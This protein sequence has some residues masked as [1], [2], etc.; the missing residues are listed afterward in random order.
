VLL[1]LGLCFISAAC[2]NGGVVL[3]S[4][5]AYGSGDDRILRPSLFARLVRVR[6]WVLGTLLNVA[7]WAFQVWA[8]TL[9]SL[10]FVQP[11]LGVGVLFLLAFAWLVFGS[12]PTLR[13]VLSAS[14]L[15][16]GIAL[17]TRAAPP[18]QTGTARARTWVAVAVVL[19]AVALA[20]LAL[21]A[22]KRILGP[23][24]LAASVGFAFALTGLS[25]EVT[26]RGLETHRPAVLA[27]GAAATAVFGAIGFLTETSAL[28][29]A[30]VTAVVP[31]IVVVDTVLP[32][33]LAPFL[34]DERWPRSPAR[35]AALAAGIV[36]SVGGAASL[37]ASPRITSLRSPADEKRLATR[38]DRTDP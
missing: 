9:A 16:A 1:A 10:T 4:S 24:W 17:L 31:V 27:G 23:L 5:G 15:A 13:D 11:A 22:T 12:R 25:S 38:S 36:L 3:Q 14:A 19:A 32:I 26:S 33:S 34:F 37:A 18:P 8:L 28:V 2:Y 35:V 7:G 21:R 30:S 6:V 20:P 29:S